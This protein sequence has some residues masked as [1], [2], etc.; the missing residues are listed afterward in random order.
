MA[1]QIVGACEPTGH[2]SAGLLLTETIWHSARIDVACGALQLDVF[3]AKVSYRKSQFNIKN[4]YEESL[5]NSP[6]VPVGESADG[7]PMDLS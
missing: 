3:F 2:V 7:T 1:Q 4:F 5:L 6:L